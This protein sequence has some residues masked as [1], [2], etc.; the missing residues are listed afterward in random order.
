MEKRKKIIAA[1]NV[2]K[3]IT[4]TIRDLGKIP[5]GEL[6]ARLMPHLSF[7]DYKKAI[8]IIK[9][10]GLIIEINNELIWNLKESYT[11]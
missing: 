6:Y 1:V 11:R 7:E 3:A 4:E 8:Q 5:S 10:S 9:N 2:L